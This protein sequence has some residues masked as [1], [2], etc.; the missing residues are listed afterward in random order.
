MV[1]SEGGWL[2]HGMVQHSVPHSTQARAPDR[3]PGLDDNSA[4][5]LLP[6]DPDPG[7]HTVPLRPLPWP[8]RWL[9]LGFALACLALGIVG[10]VVPG[11]PTTVFVLMAAWAAARSS[12]RLYRW[13][14]HH[15]LFGPSLRNWAQGGKVSRRAKWTAA[16]VMAGSALILWAGA[17]PA[18]A[19]ALASLCMASVLIWLWLR[20]EP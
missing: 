10:I 2:M 3:L 8:V 20:P 5:A 11:L 15:R 19:A 17:A 14:W 12:P 18:W 7:N 6:P 13:L 4:M 16:V 9:L 1:C